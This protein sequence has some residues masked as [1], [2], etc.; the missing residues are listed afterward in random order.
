MENFYIEAGTPMIKTENTRLNGWIFV[1]IEN[2]DLGSYVKDARTTVN[3]QLSLPASYSLVWSGQYEYMEKANTRLAKVI[4]VTLAIIVILQYLAFRRVGEVLLILGTLP[5]ALMG[6][7][8]L[9]YLKQSLEANKSQRFA[10]FNVNDLKQAVIEG[11]G[12]VF[13]LR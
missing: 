11:A 9:L 6:V 10:H 7:I 8:M 5:F 12:D 1:D 2:R 4:P 13:A 3:Q